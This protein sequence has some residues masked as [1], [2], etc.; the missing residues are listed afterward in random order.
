ME[1]ERG[2]IFRN[3]LHRLM[4]REGHSLDQ[5]ASLMK[6]DREGRKWLNRIYAHGLCRPNSKTIPKLEDLAKILQIADYS[7]MWIDVP[8]AISQTIQVKMFREAIEIFV[9]HGV[10][11]YLT[12]IGEK[13]RNWHEVAIS[14]RNRH[15]QKFPNGN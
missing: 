1:K 9:E 4:K 10:Q 3:K 15:G 13:L 14:I 7:S 6:L 8:G 2:K 5:L 12:D 11:F